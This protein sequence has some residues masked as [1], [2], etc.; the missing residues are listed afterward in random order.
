[1][2]PMIF[3]ILFTVS[4]FAQDVE[5]QVRPDALYVEGIGGDLSQMERIFFHIIVHNIS[6]APLEIQWVRFDIVNPEGIVVSGQYSGNAL[7]ALFD[8]SIERRRIEPTPTGTLILAGDERKAISD[9]F[10]DFPA[11]FIG[12][13]MLVEVDYKLGERSGFQKVTVPLRRVEGFRGRLPFDG[14]WY[15]ASEHGSHDRHK[16]FLAEAFAYDFIQIGGDGRSFQRD[17]SRNN[18]YFAYGKKV[19]AAKDGTVVFVRADVA[20]NIPGETNTNAPNGNV[21][22][23]DHGGN[24]YGFYGHLR[25]NTI[26]VRVGDRVRGGEVIGEVGNSGDSIE[27]HLHVH[28]MNSADPAQAEGLPLIFESWKGQAYG[29]SP[30]A[31][32][33]GIPMR[34]EFVQP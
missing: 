3:A 6:K 9:I 14:I 15:V 12:Q 24:Q 13:T 11:A 8:S 26:N 25:P 16:R 7:T 18:D 29:R 23:I 19:L 20:E 4:A 17:G 21:V 31:G 33:S 10:M 22:I 5:L 30:L 32:R 28:V 2:R 34:G 1:M 27:P